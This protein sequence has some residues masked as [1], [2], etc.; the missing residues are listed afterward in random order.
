MPPEAARTRG[1]H[2][3][4]ARRELQDNLQGEVTLNKFL[5]I[6]SKMMVNFV[7]T[8]ADAMQIC[9]NIWITTTTYLIKILSDNLKECV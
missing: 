4:W 6:F 8:N 3:Y 5:G 7:N 1:L 9:I 2:Y